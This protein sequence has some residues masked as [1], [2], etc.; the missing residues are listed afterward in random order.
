MP[1]RSV[2]RRWISVP[3]G[4]LVVQCTAT[5]SALV[6]GF[7]LSTGVEASRHI[8]GRVIG[9]RTWTAPGSLVGFLGWTR[10]PG[11]RCSTGV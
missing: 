1:W 8:V 3:I 10:G 7:G 11:R 5:Q 4:N 2:I 9:A 6:L